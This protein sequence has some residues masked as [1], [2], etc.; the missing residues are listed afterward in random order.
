MGYIW[1]IYI[2]C[3]GYNVG[4]MGFMWDIYDP[5]PRFA[6]PPCSGMVPPPPHHRG[7]EGVV[8]GYHGNGWRPHHMTMDG[9][10]GLE[11]GTYMESS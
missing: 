6:S 1:D 9:G 3:M 5:G 4:Y 7:G 11:P 2:Y 10:V 8:P